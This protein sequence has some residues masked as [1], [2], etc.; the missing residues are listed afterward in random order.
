MIDRFSGKHEFLSNFFVH[1]VTFEGMTFPSSEHAFQAAK[2]LDPAERE[3]IRDLPTCGKVKRA[4]RHVAL[5]PNWDIIKVGVMH[6]VLVAKFSD[7]E[8]RDL[9]FAT[10]DEQLVEGND[11]GDRFW[12]V[13]KGKGD[14]WLGKTLMK[15]RAELSAT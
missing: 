7:P 10:G 9:L 12:G 3:K 6:D 14:N 5:R 1:P 15:V 11:H 8:L 4:G 2:S 13:C